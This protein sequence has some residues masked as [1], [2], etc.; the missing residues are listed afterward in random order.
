M[1]VLFQDWDCTVVTYS[2]TTAMIDIAYDSNEMKPDV[3][4]FGKMFCFFVGRGE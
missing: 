4:K 2:T 3:H 1:G